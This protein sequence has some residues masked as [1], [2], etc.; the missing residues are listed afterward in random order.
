MKPFL[1]KRT[2][3]FYLGLVV[4]MGISAVLAHYVQSPYR[5]DCRIYNISIVLETE[6]E[7]ELEIYY[8]IG[9]GFHEI[10]HQE[11]VVTTT[12]EKTTLQVTVPV[13]K[14]FTKLR[15][16]PVGGSVKM[17]I[18]SIEIVSA[19]AT[20]H[21]SVSLENLRPVQQITNGKWNGQFFS[22]ETPADANDPMLLVENIEDPQRQQTEKS[23]AIYALWIF[24]SFFGMLL[25]NWIFRFCILGL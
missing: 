25:C 4:V 24:G 2:L 18:Y 9:R 20:F 8:D 14:S 3:L 17:K 22:F 21:H 7:A 13:W 10:D 23:L 12:G 11:M 5:G 15:V 1:F 19:D 6:E 16:D